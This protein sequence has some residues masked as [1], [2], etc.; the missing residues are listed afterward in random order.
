MDNK[1][2]P[3]TIHTVTETECVQHYTNP[4]KNGYETVHIDLEE[5][6]HDQE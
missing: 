6:G 5:F 3:I 2:G 4:Y 1:Y